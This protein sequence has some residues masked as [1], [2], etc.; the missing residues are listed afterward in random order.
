MSTLSLHD[1]QGI[2]AFSNNIRVPSGHR[3]TFEGALKLRNLSTSQLPATGNE[4]GDIVYN[5]DT[6]NLSLWNGTAWSGAKDGST[7]DGAAASAKQLY[8]DGIVTSGKSW[9]YIQTPNGGIV[10]TWCDFDT[11]DQFGNSGWMLVASYQTD[12]SY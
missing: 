4:V 8:D 2:S 10:R 11:Q 12:T 6:N 1:L 5:T 9:R 3:L 7:A